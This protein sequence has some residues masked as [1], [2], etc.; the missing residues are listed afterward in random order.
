M[1]YAALAMTSITATAAIEIAIDVSARPRMST[2]GGTGVAR[3]R[4]STPA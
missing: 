1:S 3:R 2:I 4:F